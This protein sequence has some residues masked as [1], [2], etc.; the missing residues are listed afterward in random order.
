[1]LDLEVCKQAKQPGENRLDIV[2]L[3]AKSELYP[4]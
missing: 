3:N 1:M 4:Y 2:H